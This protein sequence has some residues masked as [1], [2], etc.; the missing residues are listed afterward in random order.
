MK[1]IK[2]G[3]NTGIDRLRTSE[4]H[5]KRGRAAPFKVFSQNDYN[6]FLSGYWVE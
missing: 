5:L 6:V 2:N 4:K 3:K 1:I